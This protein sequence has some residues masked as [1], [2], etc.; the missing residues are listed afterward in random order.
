[1]RHW[2]AKWTFWDPYGFDRLWYRG[3]DIAEEGSCTDTASETKELY[4]IDCIVW[5]GQLFEMYVIKMK[6]EKKEKW[7]YYSNN[8]NN[9][10]NNNKTDILT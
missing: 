9:N 8:N 7:N 2:G 10:N 1:M 6:K 3:T 4:W 5:N